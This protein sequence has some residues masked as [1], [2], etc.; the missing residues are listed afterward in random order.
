MIYKIDRRITRS[1]NT[2]EK[3]I[4]NS[5]DRYDPSPDNHNINKCKRIIGK[6]IYPGLRFYIG[7]TCVS[8]GLNGRYRGKYQLENIHN[9]KELCRFDSEDLAYLVEKELVKYYR[10]N[11]KFNCQNRVPGGSGGRARNGPYIVYIAYE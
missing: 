5:P 11:Y 8:V 2:R 10:E 3:R 6:L 7:K 1:L 4:R 9:I